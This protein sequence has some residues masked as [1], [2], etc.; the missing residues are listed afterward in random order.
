MKKIIIGLIVLIVIVFGVMLY[1]TPNS[2]AQLS[3]DFT[4]LLK[5][6]GCSSGGSC[7]DINAILNFQNKVLVSADVNESGSGNRYLENGK[8]L[9]INH[10]NICTYYNGEWTKTW[11]PQEAVLFDS[12]G[13]KHYLNLNNPDA[14]LLIPDFNLAEEWRVQSLF[15][16]SNT[17]VDVNTFESI[18][19]LIDQNAPQL[20]NE[21][22]LPVGRWEWNYKIISK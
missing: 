20:E 8:L 11:I 18:V 17:L 7:Y 13:D 15:D 14:S 16:C 4:I 9:E 12:N 22:I 21:T 19:K 1:F 6:G 5:K 10:K 2:R 3:D